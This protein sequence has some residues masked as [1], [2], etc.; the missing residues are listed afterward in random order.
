MDSK[1]KMWEEIR[2]TDR[3]PSEYF[4]DLGIDLQFLKNKKILDVGSGRNQFAHDIREH[5][6]DLVSIDA[7]YA[8]SREEREKVFS[9]LRKEYWPKIK[10]QLSRISGPEKDSYLVGGIAESIPFPVDV[11]D[12]ILAEYS[13]PYHTQRFDQFKRFLSEVV[14]VLKPGGQ[15]RIF[16]MRFYK[17]YKLEIELETDV[18]R[19]A[20]D[21]LGKLHLLGVNVFVTKDDLLI[22][23]K[24][25]ITDG[26]MDNFDIFWPK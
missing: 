24:P 19:L 15:A 12:V 5:N 7:F 6:L 14:R 26:L 2:P 10:E 9:G 11:F 23:V 21:V 3:K 13:L 17:R 22:I 16:P 18:M 8:L 20:Y 25:P 4:H 1:E